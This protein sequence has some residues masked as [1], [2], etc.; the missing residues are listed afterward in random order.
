[1][2][3]FNRRVTNRAMRPLAPHLPGFGLVIH[4]GRVSGREYRTPVNVFRSGDAY[5]VPRIYGPDADWVRNVL[6]AGGC[7]LI[8]RGRRLSV[9]AAFVR[10]ETRNAMPA[11]LRPILHVLEVAEFVRLVP[12]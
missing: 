9:S 3:R 12:R 7:E 8:T 1:M 2:A 4:T 5:V 10:D 6:A 11:V